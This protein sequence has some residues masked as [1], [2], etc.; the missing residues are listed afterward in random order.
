MIKVILSAILSMH[1]LFSFAQGNNITEVNLKIDES[2]FI[3]N[4]TELEIRFDAKIES[5]EHKDIKMLIAK[6]KSVPGVLYFN[7]AAPDGPSKAV[8][9]LKT[10]F[11]NEQEYIAI[12]N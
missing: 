12:R 1:I 4:P 9:T 10:K 7:I 11:N 5:A 8:C 6:G 2:V 3:G